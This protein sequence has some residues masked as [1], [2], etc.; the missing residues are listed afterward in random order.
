MSVRKEK[1]KVL[2]N[3]KYYIMD[4]NT[5]CRIYLFL[6]LNIAALNVYQL[7][8]KKKRRWWVRPINQTR[9]KKDILTPY[10]RI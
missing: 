10:L 1:H 5:L 2:K 6:A 9:Q 7:S 3:I 8:L 4:Q